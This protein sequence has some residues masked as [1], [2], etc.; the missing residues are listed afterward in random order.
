MVDLV[1]NY[2]SGFST[3]VWNNSSN[4]G[5]DCEYF[6]PVGE[7]LPDN[8]TANYY[9]DGLVQELPGIVNVH[10]ETV[11]N[12]EVECFDATEILN[13]AGNGTTFIVKNGGHSTLIAGQK[14]FLFPGT[15]VHSGG[16]LEAYITT[17]GTFC[18]SLP[19]APEI[20]TSTTR[21]ET[22]S[23]QQGELF[24][25]VYPNPTSDK[26][27]VEFDPE[28]DWGTI[29]L[30]I[31]DL[32]GEVVL[33]ETYSGNSKMELSLGNKPAGIY[34]LHATASR[35]ARVMKIVKY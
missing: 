32:M 23:D 10:N 14:I 29:H 5:T 17:S 12:G 35:H 6:G 4:S 18:N 22:R 34:L 8:P 33:V 24:C 7:S 2:S 30:E 19:L 1:F 9:T 27:M 25:K 21:I 11:E 16:Y 26:F 28:I 31:Y 15:K 3:L 13:I 20:T